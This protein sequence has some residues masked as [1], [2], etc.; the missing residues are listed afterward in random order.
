MELGPCDRLNGQHPFILRNCRGQPNHVLLWVSVFTEKRNKEAKDRVVHA[1]F[2]RQARQ[3]RAENQSFCLGAVTESS[4]C[5]SLLSLGGFV[6]SGSIFVYKTMKV[7]S[8]VVI[9]SNMSKHAQLFYMCRM[10]TCKS[11]ISY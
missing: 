5:Y 6:Y 8:A 9:I 3:F 1:N 11:V 2:F 4:F 10:K 7:L